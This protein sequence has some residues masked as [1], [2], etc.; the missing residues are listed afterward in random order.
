MRLPLSPGLREPR[1]RR[2]APRSD[3]LE[4]CMKIRGMVEMFQRGSEKLA[5]SQPTLVI[6]HSRSSLS[7]GTNESSLL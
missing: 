1:L 6:H 2:Y 4:E 5:E 3:A 7:K